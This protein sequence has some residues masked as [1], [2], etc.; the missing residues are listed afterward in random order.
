MASATMARATIRTTATGCT[1]Y[2]VGVAFSPSELDLRLIGHM[3]RLMEEHR[4]TRNAFAVRIGVD[5]STLTKIFQK[6]RGVGIDVLAAIRDKIGESAN[7]MLD[8]DPPERFMR[9]APGESSRG[10]RSEDV[11]PP[12]IEHP[13]ELKRGSSR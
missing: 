13:A 1:R 3:R 10:R 11:R 6:Q 8:D 2:S 7:Y 4:L 9:P 5:P 12:P